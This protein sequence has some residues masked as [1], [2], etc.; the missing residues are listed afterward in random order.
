MG[1]QPLSTG[2]GLR[3]PKQLF[4][5]AGLPC[6][7]Q[8]GNTCER[9]TQSPLSWQPR[10]AL[11]QALLLGNQRGGRGCLVAWCCR[12]QLPPVGG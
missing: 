2:L 9:H 12:E 4:A 11:G 1:P 3:E 5:G 10:A 7:R 6:L 8:R